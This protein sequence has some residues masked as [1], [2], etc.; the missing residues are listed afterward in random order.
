MNGEYVG[1]HIGAMSTSLLTS[2]PG[3]VHEELF[4]VVRAED[5]KDATQPRAANRPDE[6]PSVE[7]TG[8]ERHLEERMD[9]DRLRSAS[10]SA[11]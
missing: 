6:K 2:L 5:H 4:I 9:G 8:N 3:A 10:E 1:S 11:K 7:G